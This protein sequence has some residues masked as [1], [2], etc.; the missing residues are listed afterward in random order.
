M[1]IG[2]LGSLAICTVLY[3]LVSGVMVGLVDYRLLTNAAAPIAVAID[4]AVK[5]AEGTTMG[6]ILKAF[7]FIIKIG[8]VL[9]LS[10][11][12]VVMV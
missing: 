10:S 4:E 5:V 7:P 2:I 12:M 6:S 9:G 8:A 11:T 1:P 3:I